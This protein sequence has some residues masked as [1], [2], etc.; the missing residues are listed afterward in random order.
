MQQ[1][2]LKQ[3]PLSRQWISPKL[4]EPR[5]M[6]HKSVLIKS[7]GDCRLISPRDGRSLSLLPIKTSSQTLSKL[8][9]HSRDRIIPLPKTIYHF[10]ST[11]PSPAQLSRLSSLHV[12]TSSPPFR[13]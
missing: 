9:N 10:D 4:I 5:A 1:S 12:P 6:L 3:Y 2:R 13:K 8:R 7:D 11:Q